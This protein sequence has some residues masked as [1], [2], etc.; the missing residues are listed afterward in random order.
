M[1]KTLICQGVAN[2]LFASEKA[3]DTAIAEAAA[4]L[5]AVTEARNEARVSV[6][7]TDASS[8]KIMEA[9]ALLSQARTAMVEAHVEM[10]QVKLRV[11]V[12]TKMIGAFDK[13]EAPSTTN[14]LSRVA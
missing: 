9:M 4:L 10:D 11:G 3:I 12:R 14:N 8:R 7:M 13:P 2:Q 5:T 6:V 1:D